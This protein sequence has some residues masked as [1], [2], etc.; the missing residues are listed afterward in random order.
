MTQT[1][2]RLE[3]LRI[4]RRG[5]QLVALDTHV[6]PGAVLT[7]MGASGVGKSTL[8]AA[9]TGTLPTGFRAEGRII[10]NG[11]DISRKAPEHRH[12]GILFQEELLFPHLSVGGNLAFGLP[13]RIRGR[14]ARR[15]K[16]KEALDDV[17]LAGFAARDPATLS[18]GQK[19][20]VA[21]MRMLLS[22]PKALL[23]DE[24][25]AGLDAALRAQVRQLVFDRARARA[26]PVL[27]VTHDAADAQ[28]A[29]GRLIVLEP[30]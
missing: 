27:M 12:V 8:L 4:L 9:I 2:L 13:P 26:L 11:E 25:F 23:L 15:T 22:E 20:R 14:A 7:V 3:N 16:I 18:G 29:G 1:G 17:G 30:R 28:A 5:R 24:A 21:L 10:L 6:A 19:A